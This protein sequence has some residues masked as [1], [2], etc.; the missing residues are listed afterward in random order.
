MSM[1]GLGATEGRGASVCRYAE[2]WKGRRGRCEIVRSRHRRQVN[3]RGEAD[4]FCS[5][6]A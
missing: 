1:E 4:M 3:D 6:R 5:L 2:A